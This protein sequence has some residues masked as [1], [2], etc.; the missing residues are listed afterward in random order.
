MSGIVCTFKLKQPLEKL[1]PKLLEI[2]RNI[3]HRG[4][5]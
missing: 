2:S 4:P 3:C 1:R 5:N